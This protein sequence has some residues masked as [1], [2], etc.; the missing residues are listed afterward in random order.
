MD[1][2]SDIVS[3]SNSSVIAFLFVFLSVFILGTGTSASADE[4]LSD[5]V[6]TSIESST[7]KKAELDLVARGLGIAIG[8]KVEGRRVDEGIH[9]FYSK[10]TYQDIFVDAVRSSGGIAVS[11][12]AEK[13]RKIRQ[14]IFVNADSKIVDEVRTGVNWEDGRVVDIRVLDILRER[15]RAE[16]E[17]HGY[18]KAVVEL[19]FVDVAGSAESDAQIIVEAN[20]PA[21]VSSVTVVGGVPGE[22]NAMKKLVK[23]RP[24]DVFSRD[25]LD[26]SLVKINEYLQANQYPTSKVEGSTLSFASDKSKVAINVSVKMNGRFLFQ[27]EGNNVYDDIELRDLLTE[28][29]LS[30]ADFSQKVADAI[31]SKYRAVGYHFC[32]VHVRS[33]QRDP[34]KLNIVRFDVDEGVKVRIDRLHFDGSLGDLSESQFRTLFYDNSPGVLARGIY[35]EEG[36]AESVRVL[37]AKLQDMG[38]LSPSLTNPRIVFTQ[39]KKGVEIFFDLETG[40]RTLVAGTN[41]RGV[42]QLTPEEVNQ[43][44][45][46]KPSEPFNRDRVLEAK[47][48]LLTK[49]QSLGYADVRFGQT[50]GKD[51][52][53]VIS[54]DSKEASVEIDVVEGQK[55]AVGKVEIEGNHKTK[56]KVILREMEVKEGDLYDPAKVR[57]SEEKVSTIGLFNRVEIVPTTD[58]VRTDAKDLKVVVREN[59]PG[60]GEVGLGGFYEDPFLRVRSFLSVAYR[61][62][63]GLNQ[64]ASARTE[65]SLPIARS[66]TLI[67]FVEYSGVLGYRAPY[68]F[69]IPVVFTGQLIFDSYEVSALGTQIVLQ[70]RTKIEGRIEKKFSSKVTGLYRIYQLERTRTEFLNATTPSIPDVIGSTGPGLI[71]DWRDDIYNPRSGSYHTLNV[72]FASPILFSQ[73]NS[74][75]MALNRNSF[76][77]PLLSTLGLSFNARFGYAQSLL[78]G[79]G[80][81]VARLAN[82][83]AL[84]GSGS[85]RGFSVGRFSPLTTDPNNPA[86]VV[87]PAIEKTAFYNFRAEL[88]TPLFAGVGGALFFDTG[89]IYPNFQTQQRHDGVGI[90]IRYKTP[91]GPIV[92]DLAQGLG[93]DRES[94]KF[95][96]TVGAI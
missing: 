61:N 69:E 92:I 24:G 74:F 36:I 12:R 95:Y 88:T 58:A 44:L 10:G 18:Y 29:V 54:R 94:L 70:T 7:L 42:T 51:V 87:G 76:Y 1:W 19:K 65:L 4:E 64:T 35:W 32:K 80:I 34:D 93:A 33:L 79:V 84:G 86:V 57:R 15:L 37:K 73:N 3:R 53:Y 40:T 43:V 31:E 78:S 21:R 77:F 50:D 55:Y 89:Q 20:E 9:A 25:E 68:P 16:Y 62:V 27:F 6:V 48:R 41:I 49:Y 13:L 96:F 8:Q 82:D 47:K 63:G 90:G 72:E 52:D 38:Y 14:V 45:D 30:Q 59:R 83:L 85:I 91:V 26:Q 66:G 22:N 39:D 2:I 17:T 56:P 11:L 46:L 71:V 5:F 67:P 75:I 60:V 81:P 28:E 23:L